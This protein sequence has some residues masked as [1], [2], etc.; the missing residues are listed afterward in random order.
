VQKLKIVLLELE[1]Y[2][3]IKIATNVLLEDIQF[4]GMADM[5]M[6]EM[7]III[8]ENGIKDNIKLDIIATPINAT[9]LQEI[10]YLLQQAIK[11]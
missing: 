6:I 2:S 4:I 11:L 7:L 5:T 8:K 10:I 9:K 1:L 3:M